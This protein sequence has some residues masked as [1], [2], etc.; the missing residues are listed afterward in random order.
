MVPGLGTDGETCSYQEATANMGGVGE[1][2]ETR[3]VG[4]GG[5]TRGW[6][7]EGRLRGWGGREDNGEGGQ[8]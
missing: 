4:E 3:G 7:R 6:G 8:N 2:G 5:E 1:G